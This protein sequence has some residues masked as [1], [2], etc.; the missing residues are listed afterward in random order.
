MAE[1]V[2][3][4]E[5]FHKYIGPRI[6]NV[7]QLMTKKRKEELNYIC[8]ECKQNKELEAAHIKGNSRKDVIEEILRRYVVNEDKK[9]VKVDLDKFE[10]EIILAHKPLEKY[11]RFLC[12]QCHVKYDS[13]K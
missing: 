9:L 2:C 11:F 7:I 6:R 13:S 5:D 8:E 10:K 1:I 3:T 4:S 12:A